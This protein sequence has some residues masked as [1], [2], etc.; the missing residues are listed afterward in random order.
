M[1]ILKVFLLI[2]FLST[3]SIGASSIDSLLVLLE[4]KGER[5]LSRLHYALADAYYE[6]ESLLVSAE[7]Y[8]LAAEYELQKTSPDF[9]LVCE[10]YG[11]A[12]YV[13][14]EL[15][16]YTESIRYSQKCY[17]FAVA[18]NIPYE[19]SASL[20]NLGSSW[21]NLGDFEQ[22]AQCFLEA[23]ALDESRSDSMG[24]SINYNNLGKIYESWGNYEQALEYYHKSLSISEMLND[25][26]RIA[27]R[28]SSVGMAY[29]GLKEI[30]TSLRYLER[31]LLI[32]RLIDSGASVGTRLS[33]IGQVLL[34]EGRI[35]EAEE[36]FLQAIGIFRQFNALRSLAITLNQLGNLYLATAQVR[37][38]LPLFEESLEISKRISNLQLLMKN[39]GD[40]ATYHENTGNTADAYSALKQF[41][42]YKDSLFNQQSLRTIEELKIKNDLI[43]SENEIML[44][45]QEKELQD[46]MLRQSRIEKV[47]FLLFALVASVLLLAISRLYHHKLMLSRELQL[48]NSSKDK[49]FT[50][51]S[52]DLKNP[53]RAFGNISNGLLHALPDLTNEDIEPYLLELQKSSHNLY[54]LLQNLLHWAKS[55]SRMHKPDIR[56][57]NLKE[58]IDQVVDSQH[59]ALNQKNIVVETDLDGKPEVYVDRN[60]ILTVLRNVLSNAVRYSDPGGKIV[61]G[62]SRSNDHESVFRITDYGPGMSA[63]DKEKL[64]R[65]DVDPKMIG[66]SEV[67]KRG[68][69]SGLGLILSKEL[70]ESMNG[71]IWV[72]TAPMQGS[73][74][75]VSV[76]GTPVDKS[77]TKQH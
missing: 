66:N 71:R 23:I 64:F 50:I 33:N 30:E 16:R 70:V 7:H 26:A 24:I 55:Q 38:A 52:H 63:E 43:S 12:G 28:L 48:A 61:I 74:F 4:K 45:K 40:I 11:N 58:I 49:F 44:L 39:Y 27:I 56:K 76:P 37:Y 65:I 42:I 73:T 8:L 9:N 62:C 25:S 19:Q 72:D 60:L 32:D 53:V 29:Y 20:V 46:K 36:N 69:G 1:K 59:A 77:K 21:F 2:T 6:A 35:G 22:A 3:G 41:H 57:E 10:S 18:H 54:E 75:Y 13:Y 34:S 17:N 47:S 68:K 51:I 5:D 14:N 31:S 67:I 15:D